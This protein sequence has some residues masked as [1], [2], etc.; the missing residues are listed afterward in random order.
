MKVQVRLRL[1]DH[2]AHL[3]QIVIQRAQRL[4]G[5]GQ[6][7]LGLGQPLFQRRQS[8]LVGVGARQ[9]R[10]QSPRLAPQGLQLRA[11]L[12]PLFLQRIPSR[13]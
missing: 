6:G 3:F 9:Q 7:L 8:A 12:P 13:P 10:M 11:Q 2:L 1:A 4:A 5:F